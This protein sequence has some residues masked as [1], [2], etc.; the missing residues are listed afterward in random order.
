MLFNTIPS[1]ENSKKYLLSLR[2]LGLGFNYQ[3]KIDI[4]E[5]CSTQLCRAREISSKLIQ[6]ENKLRIYRK[7]ETEISLNKSYK[8]A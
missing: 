8:N 4:V 5:T 2:T 6:N 7:I 3:L 1:R